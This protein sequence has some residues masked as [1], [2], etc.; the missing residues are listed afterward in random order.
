MKPIP[1]PLA[2]RRHAGFTL[3]EMLVVIAIISILITLVMPAITG[4]QGSIRLSQAGAMVQDRLSLA[5]QMA[6]TRNEPIVINLCKTTDDSG[7]VAFNAIALS[8]FKRDGTAELIDRPVYLPPSIGIAEGAWS[9]L[10]RPAGRSTLNLPVKGSVDCYQIRF[11]PSGGTSLTPSES[12]FLTLLPYR[13]EAE[14]VDTAPQSNFIT[15]AIDS[16][17]GRSFIYQP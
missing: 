13:Q 17:T 8:R 10:L 2:R 16:V 1:L 14:L 7:R 11:S 5:R 15:L 6:I 4:I 9:T 3:A 12:W